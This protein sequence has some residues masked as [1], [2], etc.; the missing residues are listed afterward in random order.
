MNNM[1]QEN[2]RKYIHTE[3]THLLRKTGY[4]KRKLATKLRKVVV[5]VSCIMQLIITSGIGYGL[6]V[7]YAELVI[8]FNAKRA[9]AALIQSLN[10][11]LSCSSGIIFTSLI[12]RLGPG[13]S[14]VIGGIVSSLGL[15]LSAFAHGLTLII[16]CT[17]VLSGVAMS[18]NFLSAFMTTSFMFPNSASLFLIIL[19]SGHS[20]GQFIV[21]LLY[22]LFIS[23][24]SW[25]GAFILISGI[26][27]HYIPCGLVI[28]CSKDYFVTE[29]KSHTNTSNTFCDKTLLRDVVVWILMMTCLVQY[30]TFNVESWFIVDHMVSRGFTRESGSMLVS[31]LGIGSF[32]GRFLG[33]ILQY[34]IKW[35]TVYHWV[36]LCTLTAGLH[37]LIINL[38]EFWSLFVSC[39]MYGILFA[40]TSAQ[41]PAIVFEASGHERYPRAMA[42]I[43]IACGLGDTLGPILGGFIKDIFGEYD[44]VFYIAAGGSLFISGTAIIISCIINYRK[45]RSE[46]D[47]LAFDV[48][49]KTLK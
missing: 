6:S 42:L 36:Y 23:Q 7:M 44:V 35:P 24:Y 9:D 46:S 40:V 45:F 19:T 4:R 47:I 41:L 12:D 11:G 1:H 33:G 20:I 10:M 43:N 14:I 27:L 28:H 13:K 2:E 3:S 5:M 18:I 38:N 34:A 26:S 22:E 32:I 37:A 39:V 8:V 25:S 30:I 29:R 48:E 17:G 15:F 16:L 21:P 49:Y 31:S